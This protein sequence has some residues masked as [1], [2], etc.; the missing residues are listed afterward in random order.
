MADKKYLDLVG[1]GQY[2]AKIKALIDSKDAATLAS[3]KSHAEGLAGNYDVKGSAAQ[4]LTDAKGYTDGKVTELNGTIAGVKTIAEQG[5]ADAATAQAAANKA[6]GEVDALETLVGQVPEGSATVIAYVDKKTAGIASDEAL[7]ALAGRVTTAE[8]E[9]DAIQADYLKAADKTELEGKITA[10]HDAADAAQDTA[11]AVAE[12]VE[13]FM[14]AE[15]IKEGA[16]DTLKE[17]QDYIDTHGEAAAKMVEDIAANAKAIED[18][19]AARGEAI[20]DVVEA[21]EAADEA[22]DGRVSD[23]EALFGN[24]EGSV[25]DQISDAVAAEA[26]LREEAD[27]A[28]DG[29]IAANAAAAKKAQDEVDALEGVVETLTG[30]VNGKAAQSVVDGID[31]RLQTAEGEIDAL[32]ADTHTHN[33]KSVLDGITAALVSDWNDAVAKEHEHSNKTVLDGITAQL[34][35]NWNA[36]EGNAKAYTDEKI[37]EFVVISNTEI[38]S[39]FAAQA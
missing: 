8:G 35:A 38:D 15:A 21:Y 29:K 13:A 10:A 27:A 3:A 34:V 28:L 33:N 26:K 11:D 24:G 20:A 37:N 17:I 14:S 4:A 5:V 9:I 18:E 36:A 6:Q 12:R 22:L 19:A 16:I 2:D 7:T 31:G 32:Q 25:S 39:L 30:V 23:L 1:L